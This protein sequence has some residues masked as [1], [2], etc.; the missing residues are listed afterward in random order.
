MIFS[1]HHLFSNEVNQYIDLNSYM[2]NLYQFFMP[3]L[4]LIISKFNS[5]ADHQLANLQQQSPRL[6]RSLFHCFYLFMLL[7]II[8]KDECLMTVS[9]TNTMNYEVFELFPNQLSLMQIA[10]RHLV[11]V[12]ILD[13]VKDNGVC[14]NDISAHFFKDHLFPHHVDP[15]QK[16]LML[17]IHFLVQPCIFNLVMS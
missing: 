4:M 11:R 15:I 10:L 16:K 7:I 12:V 9:F 14:F 3:V 1:F 8:I 2:F 13:Q 5:I 6:Y 17:Y